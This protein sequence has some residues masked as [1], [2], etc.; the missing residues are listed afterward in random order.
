MAAIRWLGHSSF[1]IDLEGRHIIVDPWLDPRPLHVERLVKP[2]TNAEGIKKADLI[3]ITHEHFDH[4]D[5]YDVKRIQEKT[6]A[7]VLAPEPALANLD[8][9]ERQRMAAY[10]GDEFTHGGIEV[11]VVQAK[12]PRSQY[13]VGY[14]F[15]AGGASVYHAG[16]TFEFF[17]MNQI[18]ADVALVPVGGRHTMD[19]IS[20]L[21]AVKRLNCGV[22]IPMHHGTF[23]DIRADVREFETKAK[24]DGKVKPVVLE[25]G[26]EYYF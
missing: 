25:V 1:E 20:G 26:G 22:A 3:A 6:F 13:P 5:K 16:D 10:V 8:V 21:N 11:K 7:P 14:I 18:H 19:V 2:A 23:S 15:S 17:E 24:K 4:C 9:G 12:H